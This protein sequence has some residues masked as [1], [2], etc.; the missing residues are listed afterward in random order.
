[1]LVDFGNFQLSRDILRFGHSH[2]DREDVLE[3]IRDM[4]LSKVYGMYSLDATLGDAFLTKLEA[5]PDVRINIPKQIRSQLVNYTPTPH[6][7]FELTND[8]HY[9]KLVTTFK[10]DYGL[11]PLLKGRVY[12]HV[13]G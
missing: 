7:K 5:L 11:I 10:T 8:K 6:L 2:T 3:L 9:I 13:F 12:N 4:G 1:M